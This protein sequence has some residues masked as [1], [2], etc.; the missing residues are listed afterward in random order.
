MGFESTGIWP[1]NRKKYNTSQF[2][3][4]IVQRCNE[5]VASAKLALGWA[6]C[7]NGKDIPEAIKQLIPCHNLEL[8]PTLVEFEATVYI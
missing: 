5:W 7:S 2:N 3:V 1:L 6:K 8:R 4:L